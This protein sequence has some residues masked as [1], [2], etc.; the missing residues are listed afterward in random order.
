M[1]W[2]EAAN[3]Q[4]QPFL[5]NK[6]AQVIVL[7]IRVRSPS[8][9]PPP[10]PTHPHT[11]THTHTHTRQGCLTIVW[12]VF[13]HSGRIKATK[14]QNNL[15]SEVRSMPLLGLECPNLTYLLMLQWPAVFL[16]SMTHLHLRNASSL[17]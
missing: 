12:G 4:L 2:I 17:S 6:L 9:P 3:S 7:V 15:R 16:A 1:G 10:P 14:Q 5:R 8:P 13:A 11:H